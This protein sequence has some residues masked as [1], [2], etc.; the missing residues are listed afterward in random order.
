MKFAPDP[1]ESGGENQKPTASLIKSNETGGA[2]RWP[3]G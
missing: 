3:S 1:T 2:E